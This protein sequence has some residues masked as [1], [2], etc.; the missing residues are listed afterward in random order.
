LF[1]ST[2]CSWILVYT[3]LTALPVSF[4]LGLILTSVTTPIAVWITLRAVPAMILVSATGLSVR[5]PLGGLEVPTPELVEAAVTDDTSV[6]VA[7][8]TGEPLEFHGLA[9]HPL[10]TGV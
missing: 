2:V 5:H 7:I 1:V 9:D 4:W 8:A 10:D 6:S 3:A